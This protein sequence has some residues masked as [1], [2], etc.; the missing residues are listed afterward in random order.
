M[1]TPTLQGR[2]YPQFAE[3]KLNLSDVPVLQPRVTKQAWDG[4]RVRARPHRQAQAVSIILSGHPGRESESHPASLPPALFLT[5]V[6][7]YGMAEPSGFFLKT[8]GYGY[9][10][11][12]LSRLM[13]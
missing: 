10:G 13:L 5:L 6:I 4:A 9:Q 1:L 12:T 8:E 7:K 3:E 11:D 2:S